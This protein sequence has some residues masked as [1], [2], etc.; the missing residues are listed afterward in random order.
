MLPKPSAETVAARQALVLELRDGLGGG[1]NP[2][3]E[4]LF[5]ERACECVCCV[6][7]CVC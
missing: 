4:A 6:C 7:V 3:L 1:A 5:G 2:Q